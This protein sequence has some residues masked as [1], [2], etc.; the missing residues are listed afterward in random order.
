MNIKRM[1]VHM[2]KRTIATISPVIL[3]GA[4]VVRLCWLVL[5]QYYVGY[6]P[7]EFWNYWLVQLVFGS[8]Q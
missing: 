6:S 3:A 5:L 7:A 4:A 1:E 2:S 8:W